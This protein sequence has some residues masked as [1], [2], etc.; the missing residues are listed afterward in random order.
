[1]QLSTLLPTAMLVLQASAVDWAWYC[2]LYLM[3]GGAIQSESFWTKLGSPV[4]LLTS[5]GVPQSIKTDGECK[6]KIKRGSPLK[7][8]MITGVKQ[9]M[10]DDQVPF[11]NSNRARRPFD[12]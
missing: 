4:E 9:K 10:H 11:L 8:Y 3:D 1:M 6:P 12:I 7:E 5:P 2:K